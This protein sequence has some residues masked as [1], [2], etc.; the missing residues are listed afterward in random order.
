MIV[1]SFTST[2]VVE[3]CCEYHLTWARV[4]HIVWEMSGNFRV[5]EEWSPNQSI[6]LF[7]KYDNV[8][9]IIN[10]GGRTIR[11]STAPTVALAYPK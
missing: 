6:N 1:C 4:L 11:Q 5:S 10:S 7:A 8:A 2:L 9:S 3:T